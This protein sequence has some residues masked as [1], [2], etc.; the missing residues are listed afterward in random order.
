MADP[1]KRRRS[2][3]QDTEKQQ[4]IEQNQEPQQEEITRQEVQPPTPI[5]ERPVSIVPS[6]PVDIPTPKVAQE[7]QQL[8]YPTRGLGQ[9]SFHD[10]RSKVPY[11]KRYRKENF[12]LDVRLVPYIYD[13]LETHGIN[14]TDA[15]NRAWLKV[16]LADGYQLDPTILDRPCKPEDLPEGL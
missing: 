4:E 6:P 5:T 12:M 14:K 3:Y 13:W 8:P 1:L 10:R 16:L 7:T 9:P 2:L 15:V 11:E